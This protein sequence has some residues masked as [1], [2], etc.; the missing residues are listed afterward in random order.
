MN[1]NA[2]ASKTDSPS[3]L[4]VFVAGSSLDDLALD[5]LQAEL[6]AAKF[7]VVRLQ[8]QTITGKAWQRDLESAIERCDLAVLA[9]SERSVESAFVQEEAR[10]A[11]RSGKRVIVLHLGDIPTAKLGP[12]FRQPGPLFRVEGDG[13]WSA[14]MARVAQ[15]LT[16]F[17]DGAIVLPS[18]RPAAA[19][20]VIP[21]AEALRRASDS[22]AIEPRHLYA[23]LLESC[24]GEPEVYA[25]LLGR[26]TQV[27]APKINDVLRRMGLSVAENPVRIEGRP[28]LSLEVA[29]AL[30]WEQA[31][32]GREPDRRDVFA[33]LFDKA[34]TRGAA[35]IEPALLSAG[36]D[37]AGILRAVADLRDWA[38]W[39]SIARLIGEQRLVPRWDRSGFDSDRVS[40]AIPDD[41]DA[42][43]TRRPARRFAK[44]LASADVQP[45]IA[46]GLFGNWGSGKTTFMGLMQSAVRDLCEGKDPAY[47]RRVVQLEFNAWHYHDTSLWACLAM[48]IFDG[49]AQEL[50]PKEDDIERTRRELH[51]KL[52]SSQVRRTEAEQR[53]MDAL[54]RRGKLASELEQ[55]QRNRRELEQKSV[56][57][58]LAAAWKVVESGASFQ[59]LRTQAADLGRHFGLPSAVDSAKQLARLRADVEDTSSRALGLFRA[60][61][62]RFADLESGAKATAW[63]IAIGAAAIALGL[64]V[65]SIAKWARAT[66]PELPAIVAQVSAFV[67]A[68]A[69][70]CGRRVRELRRGIETIGVVERELAE[71][72]L[73]VMPIE[74]NELLQEIEAVDKEIAQAN[75]EIQSADSEIAAATAEI[76]RINRGGLVYDFLAERRGA[77]TYTSSLGLVSTIRCDFERLGKLLDDFRKAGERPIDR[78]VLYVDDLDRCHPDK[79]VEVLQ[80]VHL[81]LA[82]PLFSVV[83]GVDARWLERSLERQY[84]ARGGRSR[85]ARSEFSAQDY[86]EKIFQIPYRLAPM[87]PHAFGRLIDSL[88]TTRSDVEAKRRADEAK[89]QAE[90]ASNAQPLENAAA[91]EPSHGPA[92][93]ENAI[94]PA[95]ATNANVASRD[96]AGKDAKTQDS[97]SVG[98][99]FEDHEEKFLRQLH[100]FI[101]RPRLAKRFLNIYRLLRV[102]A[103]ETPESEDFALSAQSDDY[104]AAQVLLAINVGHP[105]IAAWMLPRIADERGPTLYGESFGRW[106]EDAKADPSLTDG[107]RGE[108][109]RVLT[110]IA[111]LKDLPSNDDAYRRWAL[112]IAAFSFG[113]HESATSPRRAPAPRREPQAS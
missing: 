32:T 103:A 21:W 54:T 102:R 18:R 16:S 7:H 89:R 25:A 5:A 40:G 96:D 85:A 51:A 45:P 50:S 88:V 94:D 42:L 109:D 100:A 98:R 2:Q 11:R 33:A 37:P 22:E 101:D 77:T 92:A 99:F 110:R 43:D 113:W 82:F 104:R 76:D 83:V 68:V 79:V 78:I 38:R 105:R 72:E 67:A 58:R 69:G 20:A 57:I 56:R 28:R 87:D 13:D 46:L 55:R 106:R 26:S 1:S 34:G 10:A 9:I 39:P 19:H 47:V 64:G 35:L 65:E 74:L 53:R 81:M 8:E 112:P 52:N 60:V 70:W 90:Q 23:A 27:Q 75:E 71:A 15:G 6:T 93:E 41:Q 14:A 97:A 48:R 4:R 107:D 49:L 59:D 91:Q 3:A 36:L 44:L 61:G 63:L 31:D 84:V 62:Q 95:K 80:A 30:A 73:K 24:S 12:E 29:V 108:L 17:R 66:H 86:L 111:E